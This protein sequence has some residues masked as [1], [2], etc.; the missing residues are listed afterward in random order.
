MTQCSHRPGGLPACLVQLI[1]LG[2]AVHPLA[3]QDQHYRVVRQ[4][5]FRQ[6][7]GTQGRLLASVPVGVQ[8]AGGLA[9]DGWIQVSLEGWIWGA[10]VGRTDRDGHNLTV[11]ASRGENLR[12]APNGG[13]IARLLSGFL[14]DE[15]SR[16]GPWVRA[17]R[18]GWMPEGSLAPL[19]EPNGVATAASPAVDSA[20][21]PP[22]ISSGSGASVLDRAVVARES[23]ITA[24]AEGQRTG[25]LAP[26]TPVRIL[27]RS[28]DWVRVQT[29][30]WIREDDLRPTAAGL[31]LGLTAA[32]LRTRP[33]EYEGKLVRWTL[34]YLSMATADEL[35]PEIPSGQ[36]YLLARGPLP[37]AG[38]VYVT[39]SGP[40]QGQAEQLPPLAQIV[41][42]A[43]IRNGRSKYLGNPVVDLVE[44]RVRQ[45]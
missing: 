18:A 7:A 31:I 41:V 4:D 26:E 17:R 9:R 37:E 6:E 35:R 32:E 16:D 28:G 39:L 3:A 45:P 40:Q 12:T 2:L 24:T 23:E 11:T 8:V 5:N 21:D 36:R 30:G 43:K 22:P 13:V 1:F 33:Q 38:F 19:L 44:M 34:Q 27:A 25:S 15:V 29:E 14:L 10:S 20:S 42:V